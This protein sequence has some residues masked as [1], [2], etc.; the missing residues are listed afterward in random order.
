MVS[1][2]GSGET[3]CCSDVSGLIGAGEELREEP[4]S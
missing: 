1:S 3:R 2:Y 4:S